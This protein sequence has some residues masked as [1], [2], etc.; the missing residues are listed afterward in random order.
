M[1]HRVQ[2]LGRPVRLPMEGARRNLLRDPAKP[3]WYSTA[4]ALLFLLAEFGLTAQHEQFRLQFELHVY[5]GLRARGQKAA[6][7]KFLDDSPVRTAFPEVLRKFAAR[8]SRP[9][10][11]VAARDALCDD[12]P[13]QDV[14]EVRRSHQ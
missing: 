3:G 5:A 8:S 1:F 2:S 9:N 13:N 11:D 7:E 4:E 14:G 10:P 6:A 12:P